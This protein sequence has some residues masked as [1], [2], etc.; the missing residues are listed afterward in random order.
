M[1]ILDIN[2][3]RELR[4]RRFAN[5]VMAIMQ[6]YLP[7]N[8]DCLLAIGDHLYKLGYKNN[9]EFINVPPEWDELTKLQI[10]QAMLKVKSAFVVRNEDG[11]IGDKPV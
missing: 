5:T 9:A 2:H 8:K 10:E 6:D 4:A 11:V 3:A 7:R 1:S